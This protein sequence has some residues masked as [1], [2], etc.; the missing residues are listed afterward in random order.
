VR[1]GIPVK[2]RSAWAS[3][4]AVL[5]VLLVAF[6]SLAQVVHTHPGTSKLPNHSCTVCSL[7]HNGFKAERA[8]RPAPLRPTSVVIRLLDE[9]PRVFLVDISLFTRPPPSV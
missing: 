1:V 7:S 2:N 6:T 3:V 9:S 4:V 5:C 8:F